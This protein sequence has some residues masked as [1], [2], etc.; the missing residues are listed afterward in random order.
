VS[1]EGLTVVV[2]GGAGF[3]GNEVARQ[4]LARG[5]RVSVIDNFVNGKSE[6]LADLYAQRL[7]V[8][9]VDVRDLERWR[10]CS[11]CQPGAASGVSRAPFRHAPLENHEVN[12]TATLK[13]ELARTSGG[14]LVRP[15]L[16]S[17]RHGAP[18]R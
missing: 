14:R 15:D 10:R 8:A 9:R 4:L 6:N 12:A 5:A 17:L 18:R 13:P 16:G 11:A 3:I 1:L 7:N 2:T